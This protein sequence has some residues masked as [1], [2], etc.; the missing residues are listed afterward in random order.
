MN[1]NF[2]LDIKNASHLNQRVRL[3]KCL[4]CVRIVLAVFISSTIRNKGSFVFLILKTK[5]FG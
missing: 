1:I 4:L 5:S 3:L 2:C